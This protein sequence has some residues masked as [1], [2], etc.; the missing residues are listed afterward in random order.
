MG[1]RAD[2]CLKNTLLFKHSGV[3]QRRRHRA[4]ICTTTLLGPLVVACP[5][6]SFSFGLSTAVNSTSHFVLASNVMPVALTRPEIG[7]PRTVQAG[8]TVHQ[9]RLALNLPSGVVVML[10]R[11]KM[12]DLPADA[13]VQRPE[14]SFGTSTC[15][16]KTAMGKARTSVA[17][18]RASLM[19]YLSQLS[20][21]W[22]TLP[23]G[24]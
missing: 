19:I 13:N 24:R 20:V 7:S 9:V 8:F 17:R 21:G 15:C 16:A 23:S 3:F 14:S 1:D 10:P 2:C 11:E 6:H 22:A 5:V 12:S 4:L 18:L